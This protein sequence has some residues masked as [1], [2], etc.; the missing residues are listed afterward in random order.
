MLDTFKKKQ[1]L[2]DLPF[3]K[4]DVGTRF[5]ILVIIMM[6]ALATLALGGAEI[7]LSLRGNWVDAITGHVTIEIPATAADGAVRS[8][9]ELDTI[10]SNMIESMGVF[11]LEK[12]H[13]LKREEVAKLIEPWLGGNTA[14]NDLPLP[15]LIGVTFPEEPGADDIQKLQDIVKKADANAIV[16]T[17]QSW[18][19]DLRRFSGVLLLATAFMAFAVI[20]CCIL[21]VSGA[22]NAQLASHQA[23]IDL[24][25]LMG[26]TDEYIGSQFV[27]VVATDVGRAA[28]IGTIIGVLFLK[29][30]GLIAGG[31]QSA[32]I[33]GFSWNLAVWLSFAALPL[34]VTAL[35]FAAARVTVLRSLQKMP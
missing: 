9:D 28:T 22:V 31:M 7:I 26:A 15:V 34:V 25:H 10:A 16:E 19:D 35:C 29:I 18:L 27:R 17:H 20:A 4:E 5:V 1:K 2:K 24:L 14:D 12:F 30:G 21:C 23:D 6:T 33:P 3:G 13:K 11:G 8:P 32:M